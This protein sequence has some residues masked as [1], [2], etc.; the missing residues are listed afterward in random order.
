[1]I[2]KLLDGF[3][4]RNRALTHFMVLMF[5]LISTESVSSGVS[6]SF[7]P[8]RIEGPG[9]FMVKGPRLLEEGGTLQ[10][11]PQKEISHDYI[12]F[13]TGTNEEIGKLAIDIH[14][15]CMK[16]RIEVLIESNFQGKGIGPLVRKTFLQ[17]VMDP[18][19][20][21][22]SEGFS[23]GKNIKPIGGVFGAAEL[24][25][26]PSISS[27]T[28]TQESSIPFMILNLGG[29]L[30][31]LNVYKSA[32][33]NVFSSDVVK[34][35]R[36]LSKLS[37]QI[38]NNLEV[39]FH[40]NGQAF[41]KVDEA[42]DAEFRKLLLELLSEIEDPFSIVSILRHLNETYSIPL[43]TLKR[44]I[45]RERHGLLNLGHMKEESLLIKQCILPESQKEFEHLLEWA[46]RTL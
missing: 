43:D 21:E 42:F 23:Q 17:K 8:P 40:E 25:N 24:E 35:L 20:A 31:V 1:M 18:G 6:D 5:L 27:V 10:A 34:K 14:K 7:L 26:Y 29:R 39:D 38:L 30:I 13:E 4:K 45:P 44:Y 46:K 9:F 41:S 12:I 16:G 19:V 37:N 3:L 32:D 22:N 36:R 33:F 28:K 15:E 11:N 2:I